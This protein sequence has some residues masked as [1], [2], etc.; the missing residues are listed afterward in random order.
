MCYVLELKIFEAATVQKYINQAVQ[1]GHI[2]VAFLEAVFYCQKFKL[3]WIPSDLCILE[4]GGS[5][6]NDAGLPFA[7]LLEQYESQAI[8]GGVSHCVES[9]YLFERLQVLEFC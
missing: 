5:P 4:A 7:V 2:E 9:V 3:R 6:L 8:D 1:M